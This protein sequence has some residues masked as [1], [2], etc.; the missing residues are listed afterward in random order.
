MHFT[1]KG[2]VFLIAVLIGG[3]LSSLVHL[4]AQGSLSENSLPLPTQRLITSMATGPE[5]YLWIGTRRGLFRYDGHRYVSYT[6]SPDKT[7]RIRHN[8]VLEIFPT[9]DGKLVLYNNFNTV[10][11]LD[12]ISNELKTIDLGSK[13]KPRG[14]IRT[15]SQQHD[16]RIFFITEHNEGYTLFEYL[17]G[18][19]IKLFDRK[20]S[21]LTNPKMTAPTSPRFHLAS[22]SDGSILLYD[23]ENGLLQFSREGQLLRRFTARTEIGA[24]K[25]VNFF[26]RENEDCILLSYNKKSG[27]YSL[28]L[29]SGKISK[30]NRFKATI[31]YSFCKADNNGNLLLGMDDFENQLSGYLILDSEGRMTKIENKD[32]R[33]ISDVIVYGKDFLDYFYTVNSEGLIKIRTGLRNVKGYLDGQNI[34]MRGMIEDGNGNLII[35]SERHGWYKLDLNSDN[36]APIDTRSLN[37]PDLLPP[38]YARNVLKDDNN[39]IWLSSYGNPP[40]TS[41][42]DGY[43]LRYRPSDGSI[44]AYKNKY[45]IEAMMMARSGLMYLASIGILQLFDPTMYQFTDIEGN[46]GSSTDESIIPNCIIESSNGLIW[47][48]TDKGLAR[49]DT[50]TQHFEFFGAGGSVDMQ[51]INDNIM[52]I[53]E[54]TDGLLWLGTQ[55]GLVV[56][57]PT[58]AQKEV[59]TIRNGLPDNNICGLLSDEDGGLWIS[60]FKGLSYLDMES[61]QFRNFYT[62]AGFNHNE[63]NRH[64]LYRSTDGTY[65][66][67]GMDGFNTFRAEER[68]EVNSTPKILLSEITFFNV[69]GDSLITKTHGLGNLNSVTL[70]ASNRFLQVRF[71]LDNYTHPEQNSYAVFLEGY[72]TDWVSQGNVSEVRYNN[73]SPGSYRLHIKGAG[74]SGTLSENTLMLDILV[75]QFFYKSPWFYL[76]LL[77]VCSSLT[78]LWISRL[79]SEKNRLAVEVGKRTAQIQTDKEIIEKQAHELQILDRMKSRF[80]ANIS[81]EL[82]TPLT[83]I[84]SPLRRIR[85]NKNLDMPIIQQHLGIMEKNGVLLQQQ[86][87]ELLELSRLDAGKAVLREIPVGLKQSVQT[88]VDRFKPLS[89]QKN[90]DLSLEWNLDIDRKV[91]L[92]SSKFD[93]I[94]GNLLSNAVKFTSAGR[95]L[96][97]VSSLSNSE[98]DKDQEYVR[99]M[100]TDTGK[101]MPAEE[102]PHIFNRYYQVQNGTPVSE[103]TG[104]GLSMAKEFTEL[105]GGKIMVESKLGSGSTFTLILPLKKVEYQSY[106]DEKEDIE[107]ENFYREKSSNTSLINSAGLLKEYEFRIL[108]VEDNAD[109][110]D[111]L[112]QILEV[113]YRV[114]AVE[115][116]KQAFTYLTQLEPPVR[117]LMVLSDVMMP[118]MDGFEL[119]DHVRSK[120]ELRRIPFIML[121]AK[122]GDENR[123]LALRMGVDD[124]L[125]KP[126]NEEELLVRI[127]NL[128]SNLRMRQQAKAEDQDS[129]KVQADV[130]VDWLETLEN[131]AL[132]FLSDPKMGMDL[133]AEKLDI[134]RSSLYRRIK[135]ETGLTPNMYLREIRLQEARRLFENRLVMTVTEAGQRVGMQKRAYFSKLYLERFGRLPS[136]YFEDN[137]SAI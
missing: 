80:F 48:G 114:D 116:G 61:K 10:D 44:N 106:G 30:D 108:L 78:A 58:T 23:Q 98:G 52:S 64:S 75:K 91:L 32:S 102:L 53:Y 137:N 70:P 49:F 17:S 56:F 7:Y 16:G 73:L 105:M 18:T 112:R 92:D 134:S 4:K 90:I 128:L 54:D 43:L 12:P 132:E 66:L 15:A 136:S 33:P 125:L 122:A 88:I 109:L 3:W 59:F 67:G 99:L 120:E 62:S 96:V 72:D 19:F 104:I 1:H 76:L 81:H 37:N 40:V 38:Q 20:E 131:T 27:I 71:G 107:L 50:E 111:F 8:Y 95:V 25:P 36:I 97:Q 119:L 26:Q 100:V 14:V 84:L 74:P 41:T 2:I 51:W 9:I 94:L 121:T 29:P 118:E 129:I 77:L 60:T 135:S 110:R 68:M 22:Q 55:G 117:N 5:G 47:I 115:N 46:Y 82:R 42:P 63:F 13:T 65:L 24:G 127:Y 124:Y 101:G 6:N 34:S 21:R 31:H 93:K 57:N 28:D 123:L 85:T 103:G 130:S 89:V 39:D 133:L 45:R 83:L 86:I 87:E 11:I 126:F 69:L 35:A 79:R 113:S